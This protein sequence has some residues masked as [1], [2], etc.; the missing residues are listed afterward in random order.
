[1]HVFLVE[2]SHTLRAVLRAHIEHMGGVVVGE[3][4]AVSG[5]RQTRPDI[6]IVD[7][8]LEDG[9]GLDV[10][11]AAK[12]TRPDLT[13]FVL[14]AQKYAAIEAMCKKCG[15][16]FVFEKSERHL[17]RFAAVLPLVMEARCAP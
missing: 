3:A 1:M 6:L 10:I 4:A 15:A 14:T 16:D 13:V 11:R 9:H 12:R 5:I 2:D 7:L 17:A 8:H